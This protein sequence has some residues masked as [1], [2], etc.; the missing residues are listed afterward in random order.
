MAT[1]DE[2]KEVIMGYRDAG[3]RLPCS[4]DGQ[5]IRIDRQ[6]WAA[7]TLDDAAIV[8]S[9]NQ[10]IPLIDGENAMKAMY[11]EFM[12]ARHYIL[13]SGWD[14]TVDEPLLGPQN[15]NSTL[16]NLVSQVVNKPG[17]LVKLRLVLWEREN[18]DL[19]QGVLKGPL[20]FLVKASPYQIYQSAL[21]LQRASIPAHSSPLLLKDGS[22]RPD[23][24]CKTLVYDQTRLAGSMHQ[25]TAVVDG[26]VAFCG[27]ID[28]AAGRW[29]TRKHTNWDIW[30]DVHVK[31]EGPAVRL[32]QE[33]FLRRWRAE[34]SDWADVSVIAKVS[35]DTQEQLNLMRW[36]ADKSLD[37]N[38]RADHGQPGKLQVQVIRSIH[39]ATDADSEDHSVLESYARAILNARQYIYIENQYFNCEF[40]TQLIIE[41]LKKL[42]ELRVI[43]LLPASV[44]DSSLYKLLDGGQLARINQAAPYQVRILHRK[45]VQPDSEAYPLFI[46]AKVMIVDDIYAT[47]GSANFTDRSFETSDEELGIAW[48]DRPGGSVSRFRKDL[49]SEHLNLAASDAK[50][51]K[52]TGAELMD[53]WQRA[54]LGSEFELVDTQALK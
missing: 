31:I 54:A 9:G 42:R 53:L 51:D 2:T 1:T 20:A 37:L 48:M 33:N 46:H 40:L 8:T 17:C 44:E 34:A 29:A 7:H 10:V 52:P 3:E 36:E 41:Q 19:T 5:P 12:G 50:L 22:T 25:K 24:R 27:G 28:L 18:I 47:I 35:K 4:D 16:E 30:H 6:W 39:H 21:R 49:W 32:I 14:I 38:L 45:V 23:Y 11:D 15:R 26:R 43:I 13:L